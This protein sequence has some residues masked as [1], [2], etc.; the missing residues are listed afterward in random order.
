MRL[1]CPSCGAQYEAPDGMVPAEGRHV[2]CSACHTRWFTRGAVRP[3]LS[4]DQILRRLETRKPRLR[5]VPDPDPARPT[6]DVA[7]GEFVWEGPDAGGTATSDGDVETPAPYDDGEQETPAPDGEQTR[8]IVR[9]SEQQDPLKEERAEV[10]V[11]QVPAAPGDALGPDRPSVPQPRRLPE[12]PVEPE[13]S[14]AKRPAPPADDAVPPRSRLWGMVLLL[15]V[16]LG[17]LGYMMLPV[18]G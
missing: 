2:Q 6:E 7:T 15:L 14:G 5:A 18:A 12:N 16:I 9:G 8:E 17:V 11:P 13:P 3:A 10:A 4:E 1:N